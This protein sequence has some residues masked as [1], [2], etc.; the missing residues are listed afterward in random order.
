[1]ISKI[2][3]IAAVSMQSPKN[4]TLFVSILNKYLYFLNAHSKITVDEINRL[5]DLIN[6][7]VSSIRSDGKSEEA[8]IAIQYF[9]K[10]LDAIKFKQSHSDRYAGIVVL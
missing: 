2:L 8:K 10:T 7:H 1:L 6:E 4:L 3:K 9:T 5:I